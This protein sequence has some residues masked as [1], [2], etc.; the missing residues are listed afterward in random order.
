M[1]GILRFSDISKELARFFWEAPQPGRNARIIGLVF[2]QPQSW[3]A[4]K[5]LLPSIS[6]FNLRSGKHV[7]FYFM[8]FGSS[9]IPGQGWDFSLN[10]FNEC[11]KEME[12]C[13]KWRYS[14]GTDL[15][16]V[17]ANFDPQSKSARADFSSGIS[18]V[19]EEL[20]RNDPALTA[21]IF[22]EKV[23]RYC[24]DCYGQVQPTGEMSETLTGTA[25][26]LHET[27]I[28]QSSVHLP[29]SSAMISNEASQLQ[30]IVESATKKL[31]AL[32]SETRL[33]ISKAQ[34][35]VEEMKEAVAPLRE[36]YKDDRLFKAKA[37]ALKVNI[38]EMII[39]LIIAEY[40]ASKFPTVDR[41]YKRTLDS[42]VSKKL[43]NS[44]HGSSRP[45]IGRWHKQFREIMCRRGLMDK[46]RH[47][48][49]AD[50]GI[51]SLRDIIKDALYQDVTDSVEQNKHSQE[52]PDTYS[53]DDNLPEINS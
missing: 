24:E 33:T 53:P 39:D 38:P 4:E 35:V 8:G 52:L 26:H 37:E 32:N 16:L 44:D 46:Y 43:Q 29:K 2:C 41:L 1:I 45:T 36:M 22:F 13:S 6:Y 25:R 51:N 12:A 17:N 7:T 9:S 27:L 42:G 23:F 15:I 31:I 48:P 5:E 40:H 47:R 20:K 11:R 10:D 18:F 3:I 49:K 21:G 50:K 30:L 19:F 28:P 34:S 14:G